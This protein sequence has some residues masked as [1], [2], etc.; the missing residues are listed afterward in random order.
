MADPHHRYHSVGMVVVVVA[1]CNYC[2]LSMSVISLLV[3]YVLM[4]QVYLTCISMKIEVFAILCLFLQVCT[5]NAAVSR[6]GKV[7]WTNVS[8]Y[9]LLRRAKCDMLRHKYLV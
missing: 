1:I 2:E 6:N 3:I 4:L 7:K 8:L 5:G 9:V